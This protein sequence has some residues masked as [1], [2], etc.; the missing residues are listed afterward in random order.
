[1]ITADTLIIRGEYDAVAP[2]DWVRRVAELIPS[3]RMWEI[4]T[5]AHSVMHAHANEVAKLCVAHAEQPI[6]AEER[7]LLRVYTE[8]SD[9]DERDDFSPS[10]AEV[11]KAFRARVRSTFAAARGNDTAL[12]EAKTEHAEAMKSAFERRQ[13]EKAEEN[14]EGSV[15]R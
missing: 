6:R 15:P 3:S 1:L 8:A 10:A 14:G 13:D 5:A 12:A 2:R 11:A 4:P 9:G 7:G